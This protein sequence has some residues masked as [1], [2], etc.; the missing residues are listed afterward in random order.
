MFIIRQGILGSAFAQQRDVEK[1]GSNFPDRKGGGHQMLG[2]FN[3][4]TVT[5]RRVC[6]LIKIIIKS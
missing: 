3:F 1:V 2:Y 4:I 6:M 5:S